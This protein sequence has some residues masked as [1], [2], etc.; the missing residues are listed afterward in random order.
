MWCIVYLR[1]L[2]ISL[3]CSKLF[4]LWNSIALTSIVLETNLDSGLLKECNKRENSSTCFPQA[5]VLFQHSSSML[6]QYGKLELVMQ[7]RA[8]CEY[9][10][11]HKFSNC[12]LFKAISLFLLPDIQSD[13]NYSQN[14][15]RKIPKL[16]T[17]RNWNLIKNQVLERLWQAFR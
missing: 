8:F 3:A 4:F 6:H 13:F 16:F 9:L 11:G 2:F 17:F 10:P 15:W 12:S 1:V 5:E 14:R 7:T